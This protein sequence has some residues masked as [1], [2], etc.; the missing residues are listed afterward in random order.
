MLQDAPA[1]IEQQNGKHLVVDDAGQQIGNALQQLIDVQDRG[2]FAADFGEQGQLPRLAGYARV[3]ASVLDADRDAGGEQGEQALCSSLKA[4]GWSAST[5]IT[6][7]TLFLAMR[8]AASSERAP[9]AEL[10]K[11]CLGGNVVDQHRLALLNCPSRNPLSDLNADAFG[12]LR[13]MTHLEAYSQ[14]LGFFVQQ[15][16]GEDFVVD[17]CFS[18]SATRCSSVFRSSVVLTASATSSR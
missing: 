4:P 18:I 16:D 6:P 10:M 15:Q 13:R 8:G 12:D 9:G 7:M 14:F 11:F 5:S 2:E 17:T 1:G 3:E